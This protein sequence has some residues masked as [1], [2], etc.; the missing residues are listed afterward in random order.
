MAKQTHQFRYYLDKSNNDALRN[1]YPTAKNDLERIQKLNQDYPKSLAGEKARFHNKY[2]K[3]SDYKQYIKETGENIKFVTSPE[4][5]SEWI[6]NMKTKSLVTQ[7]NVYSMDDKGTINSDSKQQL[8]EQQQAQIVDG[9][10]VHYANNSTESHI[11]NNIKNVHTSYD[12]NP[13]TTYDPQIRKVSSK[14]W[15]TPDADGTLKES[16]KDKPFFDVKRSKRLAD[17]ELGIVKNGK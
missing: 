3:G 2:P 7:W 13:V 1:S 8:T 6:I 10:S 5:H 4:F 11:L 16:L 14:G 12:S 17:K 15:M 9:N